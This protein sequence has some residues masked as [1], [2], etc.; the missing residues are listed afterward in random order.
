MK[1]LFFSRVVIFLLQCFSNRVL[2]DFTT[3]AFIKS[4]NSAQRLMGSE[5]CIQWVS[6]G[7]T[8]WDAQ[9]YLHI[10]EF[11]YTNE[12]SLAFFPLLPTM[13]QICGQILHHFLD[14]YI[15]YSCAITIAGH[16]CCEWSDSLSINMLL[17]KG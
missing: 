16:F 1:E 15:S 12:K 9:H 8:R 11:G 4:T 17:D 5:Q 10:A 2:P 14:R 6:E 7:L 13:L 3:D